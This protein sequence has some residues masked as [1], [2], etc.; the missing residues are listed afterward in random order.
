MLD[1]I[2]GVSDHARVAPGP[3]GGDR[4]PSGETFLFGMVGRAGLGKNLP[5]CVKEY[6]IPA[7]QEAIFRATQKRLIERYYRECGYSAATA[8][9]E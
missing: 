4:A 8:V 6:D 3:W 9:K 1:H 2:F 5:P 7:N